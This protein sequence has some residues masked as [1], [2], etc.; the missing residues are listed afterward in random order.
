MSRLGCPAAFT[1]PAA[2]GNRPRFDTGG[3]V[4]LERSQS[5]VQQPR[6][7][8]RF[9]ARADSQRLAASDANGAGSPDISA[10]RHS[11]LAASG[12]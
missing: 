3:Y 7:R 4:S 2:I 12:D 5:V 11:C 6:G 8:G 10:T 1:C 9:I